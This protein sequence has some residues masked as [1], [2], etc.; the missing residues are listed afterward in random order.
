MTRRSC[1]VTIKPKYEPVTRLLW[2]WQPAFLR[3]WIRGELDESGVADHGSGNNVAKARPVFLQSRG[4][5][6]KGPGLEFDAES[7]VARVNSAGNFVCRIVSNRNA[8]HRGEFIG[9]IVL[10]HHPTVVS[11]LRAEGY[12]PA[13]AAKSSHRRCQLIFFRLDIIGRFSYKHSLDMKILGKDDGRAPAVGNSYVHG[14]IDDIR[15]GAEGAELA[16][17]KRLGSHLNPGCGIGSS[18]LSGSG[19]LC[20]RRGVLLGCEQTASRTG[21]TE[22]GHKRQEEAGAEQKLCPGWAQFHRFFNPEDLVLKSINI[23]PGNRE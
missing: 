22:R 17:R 6:G 11:R 16:G 20:L 10:E 9:L 13:K 15:P 1:V 14:D 5:T 18:R 7:Q 8:L 19:R 2:R 23:R 21:P 4:I 12:A 3:D